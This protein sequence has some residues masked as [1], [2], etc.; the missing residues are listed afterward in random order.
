VK[1]ASATTLQALEPLLLRLRTLSG[2]T[3]RKPGIFYRQSAAFLHFHEDPAGL[4]V[5][6]KLDGEGFERLPV[7]SPA[8]QAALWQALKAVWSP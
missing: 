7:S 3:E 8:E 2:L 5:D 6:V 4:F 1:H